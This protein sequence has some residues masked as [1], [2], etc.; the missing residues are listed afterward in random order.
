MAPRPTSEDGAITVFLADDNLIVREGVRALIERHDDLR[1]VGVGADYDETVS[2]ATAAEPQVLVTDIRMPPVVQPRGDRRGQGGPQAPPRHRRRRAL[3]VRRP[4]VR[5][6][7]PGRGLRGL[8]LPAEGPR[9]RRHPARRRDPH[10]RDGRHRARPVDRR[11]P[12]AAGDHG[13]RTSPPTRRRCSAWSPRA[14]RSRPSPSRGGYPRGRRPA[15]RGGLLEARP[16]RVV[17]EPVRAAPAAPAAPRHRR[18]RGAGRDALAAAARRPRREGAPRRP[19]ASASPS[20]S[21]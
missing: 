14:S 21:R 1:V 3:P 5:R 11:G 17:G 2:G 19:A 20:A 8:R 13:R 7:A 15:G 16:G 6:R 10:G 12:R 18:P 9:R 4:R